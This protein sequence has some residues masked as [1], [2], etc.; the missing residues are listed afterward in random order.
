[1]VIV[2]DDNPRTEDPTAIV[3]DD[4]GRDR[5]RPRGR[6][7]SGDRATAIAPW[8]SREAQGWRHRADRRQG[9]RGLSDCRRPDALPFDDRAVARDVLAA[10]ATA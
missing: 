5:E 6:R 1:M 10:R 4:P 8:R 9:P 2:T 7:S 3:D